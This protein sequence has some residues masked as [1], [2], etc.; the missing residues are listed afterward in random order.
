LIHCVQCGKSLSTEPLASICGEIMGDEYTDSFYFC[1]DCGVYTI[2]VFYDRFLGETESS[3]RGPLSK[4]DGDAKV[5]RIGQCP[6]PWN[7]KCRCPAHRSYFDD[8]L[9]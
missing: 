5:D 2:E 1:P 4:S 3:T 6:E 9:D 8:A 7:K